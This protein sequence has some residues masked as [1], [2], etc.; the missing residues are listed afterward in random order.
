VIA[1]LPERVSLASQIRC[2]RREIAMRENVYPT[3]V[4]VYTTNPRRGMTQA[5]ADHEIAA[6]R[7]VLATLEWCQ[8]HREEL[9]AI[10]QREQEKADG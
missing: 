2:V 9:V 6:M 4:R 3:R 7:S 5:D 10:H 8:R 1:E